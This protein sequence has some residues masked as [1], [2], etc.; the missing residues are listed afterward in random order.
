MKIIQSFFLVI[1]LLWGTDQLLAQ[2]N[3]SDCDISI[4]ASIPEQAENIPS[5]VEKQLSTKLRGLVSKKGIGTSD[6]YAQFVITPE[7]SVVGKSIVAG[8]PKLFVLEL[9]L[10]LFIGDANSKQVFSSTSIT[11]NGSGESETKAY[12]NAF[13][14]INKNSKEIASFL[15]ESRNKIISYYDTNYPTII[16][17]A[18]LLSKQLQYDEAM[19]LLTAIPE[20]SIGYDMGMKAAEVVYQKYIDDTCLE[21][22]NEAKSIWITTQ[23]EYGAR[24]A[25]EHIV[26]I[27]PESKCYAESVA[28]SNEMKLKVKADQD[29]EK[30]REQQQLDFERK[31]HKD[32]QELE[33]QRIAA[34]KA[35][36]IEYAK[37]QQNEK[38]YI[39][40]NR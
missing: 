34:Y 31:K 29:L 28:L 38:R 1:S 12:I 33:K 36:S 27:S 20:C 5:S 15:E 32:K 25:L 6:E 30:K 19:F 21:N 35:V 17:Q 11:I 14:R 7:I 8:P 18:E 16:K 24:K 3:T 2:N 4:M 10:S 26:L 23:D 9:E 37:K 22:I 39:I 13:K 40:L